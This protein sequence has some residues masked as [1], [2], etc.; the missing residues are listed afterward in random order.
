ML[1]AV[2]IR[3]EESR[4]EEHTHKQAPARARDV[5]ETATRPRRH[6]STAAPARARGALQS[7]V[8]AR[9]ATARRACAR[10][11]MFARRPRIAVDAVLTHAS[12]RALAALAVCRARF[13]LRRPTLPASPVAA[14]RAHAGS[15][16]GQQQAA[17]HSTAAR[18]RGTQGMRTCAWQDLQRPSS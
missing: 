5:E 18:G 12:A 6:V 7:A 3:K 1:F 16:T 11:L 9:P 13:L 8:V 17:R 10:L 14:R 4:H 15:R 2:L